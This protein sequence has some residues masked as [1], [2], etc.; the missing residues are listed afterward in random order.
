MEE[1]AE[2][3]S[4]LM[5]G[6]RAFQKVPVGNNLASERWK[7]LKKAILAAARE[8]H[9]KTGPGPAHAV[10]AHCDE[11]RIT[12]TVETPSRAS[13]MRFSSFDLFSVSRH[14]T[15]QTLTPES[16]M[17]HP[18]TAR[19]HSPAVSAVRSPDTWFTYRH[20]NAQH[21]SASLSTVEVAVKHISHV[22]SLEAL[23]GFNNTGNVC[24]WPSEEV[25]GF[26][27]LARL[28]DVTGCSVCELGGGMTCLAGLMLACSQAPREVWLTDGN[29]ASVKNVSE[30]I[31]LPENKARFGDSVVSA[32]VLRWDKAFLSVPCSHDARYDLVIAADC[33]FFDEVHVEL[34]QVILKL[35]KMGGAA[36]LF[37]PSRSGSLDRFCAVASKWFRVGVHHR[38]NEEVWRKHEEA[39]TDLWEH[40]LY[41]TDLH[42]PLLVVL[43]PLLH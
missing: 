15:N 32:S 18:G 13:V 11:E 22:P 30:I 28:E 12:T 29:E 21:G 24:L 26:H 6:E 27:C 14:G 37:A 16:Q 39:L 19:T 2:K 20:V 34:A 17:Q 31:S 35:L 7:L 3:G 33:L 9:P 5:E 43:Q 25:M 10:R 42:Y 36:W 40:G 4:T 38:Y 23:L 41:S 8:G 1:Q